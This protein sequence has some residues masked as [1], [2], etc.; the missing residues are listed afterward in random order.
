M[1]VCIMRCKVLKKDQAK[2]VRELKPIDCV[3]RTFLADF[4]DPDYI[5]IVTEWRNQ[6]HFREAVKERGQNGGD[7]HK[8][9]IRY[10]IIGNH[11][12]TTIEG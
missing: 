7:N 6:K 3:R 1:F 9:L 4:T 10:A 8:A 5:E 11:F 2:V 12:Y